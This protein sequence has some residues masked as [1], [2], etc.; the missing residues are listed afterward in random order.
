MKRAVFLTASALV[1]L[2]F[3]SCA[4]PQRQTAPSEPVIVGGMI[5]VDQGKFI[6][7]SDDGEINEKPEHEVFVSDFLIDRYEVSA[8]D[9]AAFLNERG[10]PDDTYFAVGSYST[11]EVSGDGKYVPREGYDTYPANNVTWHGASAY[12]GWV[13]KRLP[14]EAEWEKAARGYDERTFPW[15]EDPPDRKHARYDQT[16]SGGGFGVLTPVDSLPNGASYYG[17]VNMAGNVW[18]WTGD[19]YRQ[20][21]CNFC[22]DAGQGGLAASRLLGKEHS[23]FASRWE[24]EMVDPERA[25]PKGPPIGDFKVLRGGSWSDDEELMK[26]TVRYWRLPEERG[27][28]MGFRCARDPER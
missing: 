21:Y 11:I 5:V 23:P 10:N 13:K 17:V 4:A 24:E 16:W 25:D 15:G 14:S 3:L 28:N 18:E 20:N 27:M 7:G 22:S 19:W 8:R 9:F 1:P 2:F 6:M 26:V 12:C